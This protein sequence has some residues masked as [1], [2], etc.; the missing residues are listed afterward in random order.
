MKARLLV[1]G[2]AV[3]VAAA[4]CT[5]APIAPLRATPEPLASGVGLSYKIVVDTT[6]DLDPTASRSEARGIN[7]K[8]W[9]VGT[10]AS[11][12][13]FGVATLWKGSPVG[14]VDVG[15]GV[16]DWSEGSAINDVDAI[17]GTA[18]DYSST[19][20]FLWR[21]NIGA[22]FISLGNVSYLGKPIS[23]ILASDINNYGTIAGTAVV[24]AWPA[25][26]AFI[27]DL[28]GTTLLTSCSQYS[29]GAAVNDV[30]QVVGKSGQQYTDGKPFYF[31]GG[32]CT[33]HNS[34]GE[35]MDINNSG[36]A[37]GYTGWGSERAFK[38]SGA[39][40]LTHLQPASDTRRTIAHGISSTSMIVG[41]VGDYQHEEPFVYHYQVG[42]V[43]LPDLRASTC[44]RSVAPRGIAYA[45]NDAGWIVGMSQDCFGH[46]HATLWKVRVVVTNQTPNSP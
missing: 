29:S 24:N 44:W 18:N 20:G 38:W 31:S 26:V 16:L 34:V 42:I 3:L 15:A 10:R 40:G 11:S 36:V 32:S 19:K 46:E 17:V 21:P 45:I 28:G 2:G 6:I 9:I 25:R 43:K 12:G 35:T 4:G 37:V 33:E 1:V 30:N 14:R 39:S 13:W 8:G 23:A 7:A 5:E 41:E 22:Q 27:K